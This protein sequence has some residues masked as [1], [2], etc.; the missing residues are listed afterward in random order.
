ME[1]AGFI[2]IDDA[3]LAWVFFWGVWLRAPMHD[4]YSRTPPELEITT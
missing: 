2:M 3:G 1:T 4:W